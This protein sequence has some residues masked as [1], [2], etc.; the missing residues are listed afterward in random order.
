MAISIYKIV[1]KIFAWI[2]TIILAIA[3]LHFALIAVLNLR[4]GTPL[5]TIV[6][7]FLAWGA[8]ALMIRSYKWIMSLCPDSGSPEERAAPVICKVEEQ[9]GSKTMETTEVA[10]RVSIPWGAIIF[11]IAFWILS[12]LSFN[13]QM[14][15]YPFIGIALLFTVGRFFVMATGYHSKPTPKGLADKRKAF[16]WMLAVILGAAGMVHGGYYLRHKIQKTMQPLISAIDSYHAKTGYYPSHPSALVPDYI[17]AVPKCPG[18]R[19]R[20]LYFLKRLNDTPFPGPAVGEDGYIM[21][22]KTFMFMK[23]TYDSE[24]K[25]WNEW[26]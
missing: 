13:I 9:V 21:T 2:I 4:I 16:V 25:S 1:I 3:A 10:S 18:R 20:L 8:Y 15:L 22:C 19:R 17:A 12:H 6:Y 26:D 5:K 23:Y 14:M 11:V 24:K 7:A